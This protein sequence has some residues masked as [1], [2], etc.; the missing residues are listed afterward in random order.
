MAGATDGMARQFIA[1]LGK[2]EEG[3]SADGLVALH[4]DE[5]EVGNVNV[6]EKFHG[7]EGARQFW[8]EYRETF[9][10]L[11][12]EFRNVIEG[13]E[14]VALEWT[15]TGRS[16]TGKEIAYDGVSII[17]YRDGKIA[18]FRAYF[19]PSALGRQIAE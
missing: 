4:G 17:E 10:T 11:R 5:A 6:P 1:A 14:R 9:E 16:G 18:R 13:E 7:Q 15:T 3:R 12:S 2:L 19:D 8:S